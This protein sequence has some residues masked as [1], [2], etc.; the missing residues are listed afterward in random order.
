MKVYSTS[1]PSFFF[2]VRPP[3]PTARVN[4]L[5]TASL[6]SFDQSNHLLPRACA[7]ICVLF[8]FD[9]CHFFHSIVSHLLL[10]HM[11]SIP[12][13]PSQKRAGRH[14][15]GS[16][17]SKQRLTDTPWLTLVSFVPCCLVGH[18]FVDPPLL[19]TSLFFGQC[20]VDPRARRRKEK[21]RI[22]IDGLEKFEWGSWSYDWIQGEK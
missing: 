9:A 17:N 1:C 8:I 19:H 18:V 13:I 10:V 6:P 22:L 5:E 2:L 14:L 21:R 15:I 20:R 12:S 11:G 16:L 4:E 7:W 3:P